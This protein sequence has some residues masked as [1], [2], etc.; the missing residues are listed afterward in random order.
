VPA[1]NAGEHQPKLDRGSK[2]M[3][4]KTS[5]DKTAMTALLDFLSQR[6]SFEKNSHLRSRVVGTGIA[7]GA[8]HS[9]S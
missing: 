9:G 4:T 6:A 2:T 3:T 1:A 7:P 8:E 5:S